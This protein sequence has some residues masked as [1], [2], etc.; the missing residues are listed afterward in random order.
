[1]KKVENQTAE[2]VAVTTIKLLRPDKDRILTITSDR[3]KEFA[4]HEKVANVLEWDYYLAHPDSSWVLNFMRYIPL[5]S[6]SG[7]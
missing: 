4:Y 5:S 1:M 7:R 3:G 2:L 6:D